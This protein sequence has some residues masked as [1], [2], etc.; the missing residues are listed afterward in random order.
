MIGNVIDLI[1]CIV[2]CEL[3]MYVVWDI[4]IFFRYVVCYEREGEMERQGQMGLKILWD[5]EVNGY[6]WLFGLKV[7]Y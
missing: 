7:I 5:V 1:G 2:Q 4:W 6:F 3:G